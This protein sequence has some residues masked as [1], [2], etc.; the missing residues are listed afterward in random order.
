VNQPQAADAGP[1]LIL[2]SIPHFV[3]VARA[4]GTPEYLNRRCLEHSGL[5]TADLS[6][7]DWRSLV[8]PADRPTATAAWEAAQ[9]TS[10]PFEFEYR[11][12]GK[13]G[14]YRWFVARGQPQLGPDGH[15]VR[16]FGTSTDV[17][18]R[19][20]VEAALRASEAR[21]RAIVERSHDGFVLHTAD[22]VVQ[23]IS[24]TVRRIL[25]YPPEEFVGRDVF[26]WAHPDDRAGLGK[27]LAHLLTKPGGTVE[28]WYRFRHRDGSWRRLEVAAT[29]L[30]DDPDVRAVVATFRDITAR[31]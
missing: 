16:W 26:D 22:R 17:D 5:S 13:D 11:L 12:R 4:D 2:D 14:T 27:W 6:T 28:V 25:G 8:H 3:W 18:D 10:S 30:L 20:R 23:F 9:K 31:K 29:N 21:F 24:P 19:K 7:W 15:P 1:Y